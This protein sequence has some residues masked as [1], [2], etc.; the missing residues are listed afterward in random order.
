MPI[1]EDTFN[2]P[3]RIRD[4]LFDIHEATRRS[5]RVEDVNNLY[6]HEFKEIT[7]KYF[8]KSAWPDVKAVAEEVQHD[9][10]FFVSVQ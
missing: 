1:D 4:F 6:E 7:D 9:S 3:P 8:N 10:F 5:L 2:L